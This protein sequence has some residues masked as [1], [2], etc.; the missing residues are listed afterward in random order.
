[1]QSHQAQMIFRVYNK[2]YWYHQVKLK[3]IKSCWRYSLHPILSFWWL[4]WHKLDYPLGIIHLWCMGIIILLISHSVFHG[5]LINI[6]LFPL[7]RVK[8]IVVPCSHIKL[9]WFSKFFICCVKLE[10][11]LCVQI[12]LTGRCPIIG[13]VPTIQ[14]ASPIHTMGMDWAVLWVWALENK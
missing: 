13:L 6:L 5:W 12:S 8:I 11:L 14:R 10:D 1:M 3:H 2:I 9:K 4:L 7:R